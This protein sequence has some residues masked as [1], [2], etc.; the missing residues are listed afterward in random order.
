LIGASAEQRQLTEALTA[1]TEDYQ[2]VIAGL[3]Q[4]KQNLSKEERDSGAE[5][6]INKQ[7]DAARILFNVQKTSLENSV[8]LNVKA[9]SVE[10]ARLFT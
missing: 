7:I 10:Q 4:Q 2:R 9:Q 1:A 5:A 3:R 6:A 8:A